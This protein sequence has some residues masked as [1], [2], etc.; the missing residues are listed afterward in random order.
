MAGVTSK[1][2]T[3]SLLFR[4]RVAFLIV[5]A[6]PIA[7]TASWSFATGALRMEAR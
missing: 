1:R 3:A 2:A 4:V 5:L 7:A 6:R